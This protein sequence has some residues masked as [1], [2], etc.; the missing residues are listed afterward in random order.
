MKGWWA[1][2]VS[3]PCGKLI[4]K[5]F[6]FEARRSAP[7]FDFPQFGVYTPTIPYFRRRTC[8]AKNIVW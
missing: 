8:P 1:G 4:R 3:M 6:T 5:E 2:R 7:A